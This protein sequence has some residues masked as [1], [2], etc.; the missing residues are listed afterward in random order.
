MRTLTNFVVLCVCLSVSQLMANGDQPKDAVD[1]Y[2]SAIIGKWKPIKG[3]DFPDGTTVEFAP[4][5]EVIVALTVSG[6]INEIKGKY[7]IQGAEITLISQQNGKTESEVNII[8]L[9]DKTKLQ[10]VDPKKKDIEFQRIP[11]AEKK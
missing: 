3:V 2:K 5:G 8:K 1:T 7:T 11:T 6:K 10:L 9:I 4:T